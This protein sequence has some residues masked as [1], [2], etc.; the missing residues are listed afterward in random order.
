M[1]IQLSLYRESLENAPFDGDDYEIN[2]NRKADVIPKGCIFLYGCPFAEM[3]F[4][5]VLRIAI[6]PDGTILFNGWDFCGSGCL[7]FHVEKW[8]LPYYLRQKPTKKQAETISG[9]FSGRIKWEGIRLLI[10]MTPQEVCP[11]DIEAEAARWGKKV[12]C[13][14]VVTWNGQ[15]MYRPECVE[16]K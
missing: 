13:K 16:W 4:P 8:S 12:T 7:Y 6:S 5:V 3:G 2:P 15:V 14:N 11:I 1:N 10:G 9:L